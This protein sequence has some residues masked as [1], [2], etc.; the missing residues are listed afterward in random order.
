MRSLPVYLK[1]LPFANMF[2]SLTAQNHNPLAQN[3]S[4]S[5]WS[6][7]SP[8]WAAQNITPLRTTFQGTQSWLEY[9]NALFGRVVDRFRWEGGCIVEHVS[10]AVARSAKN[11]LG[12]DDYSGIKG[13]FS[14]ME[15]RRFLRRD[16][17]EGSRRATD[18]TQG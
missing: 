10:R 2:T 5:A 18:A 3:G 11:T 14:R 16:H 12:T 9:D 15:S 8:I 13:R 7:L 6:I 4:D 1:S 17:V